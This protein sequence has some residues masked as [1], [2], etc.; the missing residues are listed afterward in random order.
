VPVLEERQPPIRKEI[1][2]TPFHPFF[3]LFYRRSTLL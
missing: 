1:E 2:E 3:P